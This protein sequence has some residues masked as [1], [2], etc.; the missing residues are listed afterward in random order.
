[1]DLTKSGNCAQVKESGNLLDLVVD[2]GLHESSGEEKCDINP[3]HSKKSDTSPDEESVSDS[4]ECS[5]QAK[6]NRNCDRVNPKSGTD[7]SSRSLAFTI[8]FGEDKVINSKKYNDIVERFQKR[9]RRGV[10]LSKLDDKNQLSE[11][12]PAQSPLTK[13]KPPL[14]KSFQRSSEKLD[15]CESS[16]TANQVKLRDKTHLHANK[17]SS[18]RHSWSPRTSVNLTAKPDETPNANSNLHGIFKPKSTILQKALQDIQK[19]NVAKPPQ[20]PTRPNFVCSKPPL[21]FHKNSDDETVSEAGTYTLDGDNYTEEQKAKMCIDKEKKDNSNESSEEKLFHVS[22]SFSG[23]YQSQNLNYCDTRQSN[24]EPDLKIVELD[25]GPHVTERREKNILEVTYTQGM[26]SDKPKTSY[27]EKIKSKV[28]TIGDKAFHKAKSPDKAT[29]AQPTTLDM[30]SF[31]S[32]IASGVFSRAMT[33]QAQQKLLSRRNS[34]TQSQIDS[35]EY[36]QRSGFVN[37]KLFNSYTDYEK[38]RHNEYKLNIFFSHPG[39]S[40]TD[41]EKE[42]ANSGRL[43]VD[44]EHAETKNDWIKEWAKSARR[45]TDNITKKYTKY[46]TDDDYSNQFG[47]NLDRNY[48]KASGKKTSIAAANHRYNS[49]ENNVYDY[50]IRPRS[51]NAVSHGTIIQS[52]H[53][54]PTAAVQNY[55]VNNYRSILNE[56]GVGSEFESPD[57]TSLPSECTIDSG[58]FLDE[59]QHQ[60]SG[61]VEKMKMMSRPP[62]S[63]TKIPSP[64]H[65][66]R[67]GRCSSVTKDVHGSNMVSCMRKI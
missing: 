42:T 30:G 48:S 50:E 28:R 62:I 64:M 8:D 15:K 36:V 54:S 25:N 60:P 43:A 35:S 27:L 46:K 53:S 24:I 40:I 14:K 4:L 32:V 2:S 67:R 63:P 41:A 7:V 6:D 45:N 16:P 9:H 33:N 66:L 3:E 47:D 56:F 58:H 38:A 65:S 31:T 61:N 51:A 19:S 39:S 11:N 44:L 17:D 29:V 21:E 55:Y 57:D 13:S 18:H 23:G 59:H 26:I 37:D 34:L 49:R 12:T 20:S 5:R 22:K 52:K 1:M 10:S